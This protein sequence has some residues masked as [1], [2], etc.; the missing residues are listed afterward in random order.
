MKR[1]YAAPRSESLDFQV[2]SLCLTV[3]RGDDKVIN[4]ESMIR[5]GKKEW[6]SASIW[7]E[8]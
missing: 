4:N 2:E 5:S 1:T 7:D 3:S 8:E 6:G